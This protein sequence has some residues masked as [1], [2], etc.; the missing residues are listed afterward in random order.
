[1]AD[2]ALN[3]DE[4][5]GRFDLA[6]EGGDLATDNGL[7]TAAII[8]AFADARA[9]VYEVSPGEDRRGW[10]ADHLAGDRPDA[11]GSRVW[12]FK[13]EK[14][15]PEVLNRLRTALEE[16]FGWFVADGCA[17]SIDVATGFIGETGVAFTVTLNRPDGTTKTY[18]FQ[19][20]W[21]G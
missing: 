6:I 19:A 18:K 14:R 5:K 12:V 13:R 17:R 16:A 4:L 21:E 2:L 10:W 1:M 3:Y 8:S 11:W 20:F 15:T 7:T 9:E